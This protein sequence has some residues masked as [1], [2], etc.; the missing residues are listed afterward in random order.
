MLECVQGRSSLP[1]RSSSFSA[2]GS[3]DSRSFMPDGFISGGTPSSR[4]TPGS[5]STTGK[6]TFGRHGSSSSLDTTAGVHG[7]PGT[8]ASPLS[9]LG[10][11]QR[12]PSLRTRCV[13]ISNVFVF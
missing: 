10:K 2:A 8:N 6:G 3:P 12:M 1:R 7:S 11:P 13:A 5:A 4:A 9:R